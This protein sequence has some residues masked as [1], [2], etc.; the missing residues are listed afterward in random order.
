M[1]KFLLR[2]KGTQKLLTTSIFV[3]QILNKNRFFISFTIYFVI[4]S[5][6]CVSLSAVSED[7][8]TCII[9]LI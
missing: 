4:L 2:C 8:S 6:K 7:L 1:Q 5:K 9:I 3:H